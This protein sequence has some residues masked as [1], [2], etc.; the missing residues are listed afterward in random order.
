MK[1]I[2]FATLVAALT[3]GTVAVPTMKAKAQNTNTV[4]NKTIT[5]ADTNTITGIASN[6]M[7]FEYNFTKTSG[8]VAGKVYLQA[9]FLDAWVNLDSLTLANVTTEQTL[10]TFPTKTYYKDY[11]F[12]NTNTSSATGT[13]LAGFLRRPDETR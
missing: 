7:Q 1:K 2:I 6:V 9:R 10:R 8:T 11:R 3:F 13:V 5:A 4:A 12:V